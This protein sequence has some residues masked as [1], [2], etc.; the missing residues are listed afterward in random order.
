MVNA[1]IKAVKQISEMVGCFTDPMVCC[2]GGW[3]DTIP[4]WLRQAVQTERMIEMLLA[5]K[6]DREPTGTDAEAC[7]Y[8]YTAGL[9]AP[10]DH[11]YAD[12]YL[13]LS[14]KTVEAHE[15]REVPGDIRVTEISNY[16][17]GLLADLKRKIY[18]ARVRGRQEHDRA[19]RRQQKGQQ[20]EQ[21]KRR[22][23]EQ[24]SFA[25]LLGGGD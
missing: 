10:L 1:E 5:S 8:L 24:Y 12:I 22:Q 25:S 21:V 9:V 14:T 19:E 13:Y 16:R 15:K 11:D 6:E 4:E 23:G 7:A 3:G 18:R 17:M 20:K 2:P